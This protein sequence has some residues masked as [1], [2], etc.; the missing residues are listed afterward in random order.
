MANF[1]YQCGA[2]NPVNHAKFCG[3]CGELLN[4]IVE[5]SNNEHLSKNMKSDEFYLS[6]TDS[7]LEAISLPSF[8]KAAMAVYTN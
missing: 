8:R 4:P 1:C 5:E 7:F 6:L 3:N 2:A